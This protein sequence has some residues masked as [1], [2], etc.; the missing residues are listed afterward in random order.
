[1]KVGK[2]GKGENR[3][4]RGQLGVGHRH[5]KN[6]DDSTN[7]GRNGTSAADNRE[8]TDIVTLLRETLS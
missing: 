6:S 8:R 3:E 7:V 4:K 1:M 5:V 2:R